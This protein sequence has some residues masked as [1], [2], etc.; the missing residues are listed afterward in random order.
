MSSPGCWFRNRGLNQTQLSMIPF[1]LNDF[2]I[3]CPPDHEMQFPVGNSPLQK[4]VAIPRWQES[5]RRSMELTIFAWA[6]SVWFCIASPLTANV[7]WVQPPLCKLRT[8]YLVKYSGDIFLRLACSNEALNKYAHVKGNLRMVF[9]PPVWTSCTVFTWAHLYG[10]LLC[11]VLFVPSAQISGFCWAG[12]LPWG[13]CFTLSLAL[14]PL[15][16]K[17]HLFPKSYMWSLLWEVSQ[18]R[19]M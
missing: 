4:H 2:A 7:L 11:H 19:S 12:I 18:L 17:F 10:W 8:I 9:K 6:A 3:S 15:R 16:H 1:G 13:K 5:E 14:K